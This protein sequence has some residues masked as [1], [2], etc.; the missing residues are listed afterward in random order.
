MPANLKRKLENYLNKPSTSRL[1]ARN[2]LIVSLFYY[3]GFRT[4]MLTD[5]KKKNYDPKNKMLYFRLRTNSLK[6]NSILLDES[7]FKL[8][9]FLTRS[10]SNPE[11]PLI[12]S[13]KI[14]SPINKPLSPRQIQRVTKNILLSLGFKKNIPPRM[15]RHNVGINLTKEKLRHKSL[16]KLIGRVSPWVFT[17]YKKRAGNFK[18]VGKI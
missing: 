7:V 13:F 1:E 6:E 8:I 15:L 12:M 17:E 10:F 4:W 11:W 18:K 16:N 2:K 3:C 14:D 9:D 5:L